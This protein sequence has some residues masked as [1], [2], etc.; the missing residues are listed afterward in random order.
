VVVRQRLPES[1][2]LSG[3]ADRTHQ[4]YR[5]GPVDMKVNKQHGGRVAYWNESDCH[6]REPL[7]ASYAR[8]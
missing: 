8:P 1:I 2:V 3:K 4:A 5:H 6:H 7:M